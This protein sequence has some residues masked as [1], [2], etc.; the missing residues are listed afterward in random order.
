MEAK[1]RGRC[2]KGGL[3]VQARFSHPS[4][5]PGWAFLAFLSF[6]RPGFP[7]ERGKHGFPVGVCVQVRAQGSKGVSA[8][9]QH[10]HGAAARRLGFPWNDGKRGWHLQQQHLPHPS[11]W[12]LGAARAGGSPRALGFVEA[13]R[14]RRANTA[15]GKLPRVQRRAFYYYDVYSFPGSVSRCQGRRGRSC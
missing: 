15:P 3:K 1:R 6:T 14:A 11:L 4:P 12:I 5:S 9:C 10:R 8:Q 2:V 13:G 7:P